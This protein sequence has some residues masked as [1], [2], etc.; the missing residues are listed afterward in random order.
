M[1]LLLWVLLIF[2]PPL[3]YFGLWV[4][5]AR[6][7][8]SLR[9]WS[10]I[11]L[12]LFAFVSLVAVLIGYFESGKLRPAVWLPGVFCLSGIGASALQFR[13]WLETALGRDR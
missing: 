9:Q 3:I 1:T 7:L 13:W 6:Q 11:F 12:A 10:A 2:T 8:P 5:L 4:M